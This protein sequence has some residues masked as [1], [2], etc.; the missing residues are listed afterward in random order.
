MS[1]ELKW[2]LEVIRLPMSAVTSLQRLEW[3]GPLIIGA[4]AEHYVTSEG[5][6]VRRYGMLHRVVWCQ[7]STQKKALRIF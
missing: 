2:L 5:G 4:V 1:E 3:A 7:I 6:S